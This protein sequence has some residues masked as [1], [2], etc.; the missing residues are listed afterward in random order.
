VVCD[1]PTINQDDP[2]ID[3]PQVGSLASCDFQLL[4]HTASG[5]KSVPTLLIWRETTTVQEHRPAPRSQR[6]ENHGGDT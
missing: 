5:V 3:D 6:R 4:G 2:A 1:G